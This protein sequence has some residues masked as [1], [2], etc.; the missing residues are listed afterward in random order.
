MSASKRRL[1]RPGLHEIRRRVAAGEAD[2]VMVW[3]LDRLVRS[4]ADVGVLLDEG[5][6]IISAT[7]NL[8]TTSIMG[9]A[10][11][12]IL[13]VFASMEAK[14][15]GVR[16]S[17]S[18]AHLRRVGRFPGGV[19]PY[20]YRPAPH[21][22]GVGRALEPDPAEA[23]I[24]RRMF[25]E[26]LAGRSIYSVAVGLNRDAVPTRK[27]A[28]WSGTVVRRILRSGSVLGRVRVGSTGPDGRRSLGDFIRDPET[29]LPEEFWPPL[30]DVEDV[31][32]VRA[33]TTWEATPGRGEAS[34]AGRLK[35]ARLLSG[36]VTCPACGHPLTVRNHSASNRKPIYLCAGASRGFVCEAGISILADN[37]EEEVTRQFLA[38][39]SR[40]AVVEARSRTRE[41]AGLATVA[42]SIAHTTDALRAPDADIAALV[43]RLNLLR[44]ERD[45]LESEPATPVVEMV[46]TGQTFAEAWA[47]SDD[48]RRRDLLLASRIEIYIAPRATPG[49]ARWDAG[50][51]SVHLPEDYLAGEDLA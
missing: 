23:R 38:R 17:A 28:T 14:T 50:R 48:P 25:D 9:R 18:Q 47:D 2:A 51:V 29:G 39:F 30:V 11:V 45:R 10:M 42:E 21:P 49:R 27:G 37:L 15:I 6:Q 16:V 3:R 40:L 33:L 20:G 12:E 41:V 13:Q 32:R 1:D 4:V 31:E 46:E 34:V 7:E 36:L 24:V 22:D 44:A 5:L 8:D 19:V 26:V 35:A 43:D